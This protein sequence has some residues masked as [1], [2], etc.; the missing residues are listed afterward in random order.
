MKPDTT[1]KVRIIFKHVNNYSIAFT[2]HRTILFFGVMMLKFHSWTGRQLF[3]FLPPGAAI[4]VF[5]FTQAFIESHALFQKH[6]HSD[7]DLA[8]LTWAEKLE[9]L[10]AVNKKPE[11]SKVRPQKLKFIRDGNGN[12]QTF[13]WRNETD[14]LYEQRRIRHL[15]EQAR[16]K[17]GNQYDWVQEAQVRARGIDW[18][19]GKLKNGNPENDGSDDIGDKDNNHKVVNGDTVLVSEAKRGNDVVAKFSQY[20]IFSA[21]KAT[22]EE[23]LCCLGLSR[24]RTFMAP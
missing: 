2:K 5:S 1:Q 12:E 22:K 10:R 8:G 14:Q 24:S 11:R 20:G 19:T 9:V 7:P 18:N 13:I 6:L 3:I 4:C 17:G 21:Q 15:V 23:I 16:V